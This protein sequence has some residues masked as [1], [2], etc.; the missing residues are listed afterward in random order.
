MWSYDDN[1][2]ALQAFFFIQQFSKQKVQLMLNL[3]F[4]SKLL[5]VQL[6]LLKKSLS[7]RIKC[8]TFLNESMF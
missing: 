1:A 6:L 5:T 3:H 2:F 7:L 4:N 8:C